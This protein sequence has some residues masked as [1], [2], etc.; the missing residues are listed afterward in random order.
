[1]ASVRSETNLC[2][3]HITF[4]SFIF[5]KQYSTGRR[6]MHCLDRIHTLS[7]HSLILTIPEVGLAA[8]VALLELVAAQA[9]L[10]IA[11]LGLL[12]LHSGETSVVF[13]ATVLLAF[14]AV[15]LAVIG[16]GGVVGII[17]VVTTV[18]PGSLALL[19]RQEAH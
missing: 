4:L 2:S 14:L 7:I 1:M 13:S 5:K 15:F 9:A 18:A 8:T 12:A 11:H 16:A 19:W 17:R 6:L 10:L 3:I